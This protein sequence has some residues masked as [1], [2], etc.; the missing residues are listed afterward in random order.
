MQVAKLF[1]YLGV[2]EEND[3]K[4]LSIVAIAHSVSSTDLDCLLTV[5]RV[6]GY[7]WPV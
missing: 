2:T 3:D 5:A 7:A 4:D 1:M 6:G